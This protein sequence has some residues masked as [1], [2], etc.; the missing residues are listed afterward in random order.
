MLTL[1]KINSHITIRSCK[2]PEI[3]TILH[4]SLICRQFL[5]HKLS[6]W[7]IINKILFFRFKEI[8]SFDQTDWKEE[9]FE[10][11]F[12]D[13]S[14]CEGYERW[15]GRWLEANEGGSNANLVYDEIFN[16]S[17]VDWNVLKMSLSKRAPFVRRAGFEVMLCE[18]RLQ[19]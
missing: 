14:Q 16:F 17:G 9:N 6:Q 19:G 15:I 4:R 1:T 7:D 12:A 10:W 3:S 8:G 5:T 2:L 11:N 18:M 13:Q